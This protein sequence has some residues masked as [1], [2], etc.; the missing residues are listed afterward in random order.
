MTDKKYTT[1][2]LTDDE[3]LVQSFFDARRTELPDDGFTERVLRQLPHTRRLKL[4]QWWRLF[5]TAA[6]VVVFLTFDVI[7]GV[8]DFLYTRFW[9]T[10]LL[11]SHASRY[12]PELVAQGHNVLTV[13]MACVTLVCVWGYNKWQDA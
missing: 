11:L 7:N 10:C 2:P 5:C 13:L 1:D 3:R 8:M 6:A 12:V 9:D 4:L